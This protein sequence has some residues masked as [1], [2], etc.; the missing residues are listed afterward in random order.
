MEKEYILEDINPDD[1]I[2]Y[3]LNTIKNKACSGRKIIGYY[4]VRSKS[5]PYFFGID[6]ECVVFR[7]YNKYHFWLI[8]YDYILKNSTMKKYNNVI[9]YELDNSDSFEVLDTT[10]GRDIPYDMANYTDL[11]TIYNNIQ[12]DELDINITMDN[13]AEIV[14]NKIFESNDFLY[15]KLA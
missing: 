9:K 13:I 11:I 1:F 4:E 14:V 8:L 12:K 10:C 3:F 6:L 5:Q 2:E 15:A 7:A